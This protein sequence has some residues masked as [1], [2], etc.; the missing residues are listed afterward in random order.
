MDGY[1]I[2]FMRKRY[3]FASHCRHYHFFSF[4]GGVGVAAI[5]GRI[6]AIGG[7][8]SKNYLNT[9]EAFDPVIG[10]WMDVAPINQRRLGF[11]I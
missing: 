8:D 1:S 9:V 6:F 4:S 11:D 7:H 5:G 3:F 10:K 2:T